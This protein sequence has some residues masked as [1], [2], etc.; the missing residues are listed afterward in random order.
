M[1]AAS[2]FAA[3]AHAESTPSP[4]EQLSAHYASVVS[5]MA[6]S[7]VTLLVE[8]DPARVSGFFGASFGGVPRSGGS[9]VVVGAA[10]LIV[11]N[12][13]VVENA[14][15]ITVELHDGRTARARVLGTD[16]AL[17]IAVVKIDLP[18]VRAARFADSARVRAGELVLAIGAPFG[19]KHS[20][21]SGV[22]SAVDRMH[23]HQGLVT[24]FLQTDANINPGNSGGPL[25]NLQG[26]VI[27][28]NTAYVGDGAGIGFSIPSNLV[29]STFEQLSKHGTVERASLGIRAQ[30]IDGR[31]A[32]YFKLKSPDGALIQQ[33]DKA[34]PAA[35]AGIVPGDVVMRLGGDKVRDANDLLARIA[36]K[37][38]GEKLELELLRAGKVLRIQVMTAHASAATE[39]AAESSASNPAPDAMLGLRVRALSDELRQELGYRGEGT[40][41]ISQVLPSS[42]ASQAGLHS[43]LILLEADLKPLLRPRDLVD[44]AAD[45]RLLLRVEQPD[46]DAVYVLVEQ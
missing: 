6:P 13:H 1:L 41:V 33:V 38:P 7:V 46:G 3:S 15:R 4:S 19:L 24:P 21:S 39:R 40:V 35:R 12:N 10:G 37:K 16:P 43:N 36:R 14:A 23:A 44:A 2:L 31:M 27:G 18:D 22:I 8:L 17:D 25:V 9:G 26:E 5:A 29:R 34:G 20:V 11:T 30:A 28:I 32:A 45:H 42:P